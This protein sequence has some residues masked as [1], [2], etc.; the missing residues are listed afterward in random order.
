MVTGA[1]ILTET[2]RIVTCI[3]ATNTWVWI[4]ESVYWILTSRNYK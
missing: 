4:G 2:F 1:P 3:T